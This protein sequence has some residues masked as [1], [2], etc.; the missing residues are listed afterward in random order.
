MDLEPGRDAEKTTNSWSSSVREG[1][2]HRFH[3]KLPKEYEN[4]VELLEN[5]LEN[6]VANLDWVKEK[7]RGK[8][9]KIQRSKITPKGAL[10]TN[11]YTPEK[12]KGNCSYFAIYGHKA[13]ECHKRPKSR[14][15]KGERN[16]KRK[17][18]RVNI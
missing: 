10:M 13:T 8:F 9:E 15:E 3:S 14:G 12:Y 5:N 6:E 11:G 18:N 2:N 17:G 1:C 16:E 7:V 4:T